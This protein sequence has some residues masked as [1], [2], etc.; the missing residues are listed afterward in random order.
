MRR[1]C[2]AVPWRQCTRKVFTLLPA[3]FA[4]VC[5]T[6]LLTALACTVCSCSST[7]PISAHTTQ[8]AGAPPQRPTQPANVRVLRFEPTQPNQNIGEIVLLVP[9]DAALSREQVNDKL[10]Q[11]AAKLG[12]DAVFVVDDHFQ[13][14]GAE[15]K[16]EWHLIAENKQTE[17]VV[18]KAMK[19]E[20]LPVTGREP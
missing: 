2:F 1:R 3:L 13:P 12:A 9:R 10:R 6:L 16:P 19:L 15:F 5:P 14:N 11:E 8:Y 20:T 4:G 18:A 17:K 7:S